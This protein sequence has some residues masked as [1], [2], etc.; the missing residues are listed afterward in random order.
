MVLEIILMTF[1]DYDRTPYSFLD[2]YFRDGWEIVEI[3]KEARTVLFARL[4]NGWDHGSRC[5][6]FRNGKTES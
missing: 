4:L 5:E 2:C 1:E 6:A 3:N